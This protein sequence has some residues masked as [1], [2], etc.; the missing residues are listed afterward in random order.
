MGSASIGVDTQV[1]DVLAR[2]N[3]SPAMCLEYNGKLVLS[4]GGLMSALFRNWYGKMEYQFDI[5]APPGTGGILEFV[6]EPLGLGTYS[7]TLAQSLRINVR[8]KNEVNISVNWQSNRGALNTLGMLPPTNG[9]FRNTFVSFEDEVAG[10]IQ[11][12]WAYSRYAHNGCIIVRLGSQLTLPG[13]QTNMKMDIVCWGK[14]DP[15]M[16]FWDFGPRGLN[17]FVIDGEVLNSVLA[18]GASSVENVDPT[19]FGDGRFSPIGPN[20][21]YP[22]E[23]A[24]TPTPP[25]AQPVYKIP[26][27]APQRAP[28]NYPAPNLAKA[29]SRNP[30]KSPTKNPVRVPT[31]APGKAPTKVPTPTLITANPTALCVPAVSSLVAV[32]L[33]GMMAQYDCIVGTSHISI[34]AAGYIYLR[35]GTYKVTIPYSAGPATDI[36]VTYATIDTI[37]APITVAGLQTSFDNVNWTT[38]AHNDNV[39]TQSTPITTLVTGGG[40]Q[41]YTLVFYLKVTFK[42]TILNYQTRSL[43][44]T[45]AHPWQLYCHV[46]AQQNPEIWYT[47]PNSTVR[48]AP[49]LAN[50]TSDDGITYVCGEFPS[51]AD[52]HYEPPSSCNSAKFPFYVILEGSWSLVNSNG[53][54]TVLCAGT[55]SLKPYAGVLSLTTLTPGFEKGSIP[56][57]AAGPSGTL[58]AL[59]VIYQLPN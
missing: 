26:T 2:I 27:K 56:L 21:P 19:N 46:G 20:F 6:Y 16:I 58:S 12:E 47:T 35:E 57:R 5:I 54:T 59:R 24:P 13:T 34:S 55:T 18:Q 7:T 28:T 14:C 51:G 17:D 31:G 41:Y 15:K 1:G 40:N 32:T 39:P 49:T 44:T 48:H 30:T 37:V 43:K 45:H 10:D 33:P 25:V 52:V 4:G 29:P 38:Q 3:V 22:V 50:Y 9:Q 8:D 53:S 23:T 42:V 11:T 36:F